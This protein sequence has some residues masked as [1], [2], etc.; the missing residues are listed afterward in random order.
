MT[1]QKPALSTQYVLSLEESQDGFKLATFGKKQGTQFVT[2][3]ISIGLIIWGFYNGLQ[4]VGRYYVILGAV[5]LMVHTLIR[6]VLLPFIFKRQFVKFQLG[7][8]EQALALYQDYI[9][10]TAHGKKRQIQYTDVKRFAKGTLT[11]M[12]EL[13]T[14]AVIIVPQHAFKTVTD[15]TLFEN[16]FKDK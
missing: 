13:K 11:Y 12:I 16:S 7:K 5:F 14:K 8:E 1:T 6:Y 10:I 15:Q 2:P 4:T 9:Q 3:L